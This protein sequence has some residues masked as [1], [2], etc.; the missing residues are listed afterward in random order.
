MKV[1]GFMSGTSLDGVDMAIVET[2]GTRIEALG[3]CGESPLSE[4]A[5]SVILDA[6]A[7]ARAWPRGEPEPEVFFEAATVV[8]QEH[9][10]AA[11]AFLDRW[12]IAPTEIDLVGFHG[13]TVLHERPADGSLGRTVELGDAALLATGLGAPVA[14]DF[15]SADVAA[16]GQGAPLAPAYHAARARA[17]RRDRGTSTSGPTPRT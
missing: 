5:R 15:R 1:L 3:P 2:D 13:Q 8:A 11:E 9:L 12:R 4:R 14:F 10:N 16:G 6:I 17:S 7:A